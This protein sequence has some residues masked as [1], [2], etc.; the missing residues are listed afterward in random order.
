MYTAI[1]VTLIL[2]IQVVAIKVFIYTYHKR[3]ATEF[4]TDVIEKMTNDDSIKIVSID[5]DDHVNIK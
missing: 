5:E 3:D 2:I 4:F 1:I